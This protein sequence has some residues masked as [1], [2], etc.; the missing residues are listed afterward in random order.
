MRGWK[1]TV[2]RPAELLL[3]D[4]GGGE[5]TP[6]VEDDGLGELSRHGTSSDSG[7]AVIA[8]PA[9]PGRSPGCGPERFSVWATAGVARV[10]KGETKLMMGV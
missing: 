9:N 3:V 10:E 2:R 6:V 7:S 8:R 1:A 5:P 4:P